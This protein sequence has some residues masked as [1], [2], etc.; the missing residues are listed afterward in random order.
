MPSRHGTTTE[1]GLLGV[2]GPE[3]LGRIAHQSKPFIRHFINAHLSAEPK[4]SPYRAD[5]PKR[6]VLPET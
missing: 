4:L 3:H 1:P 6:S 5:N 2:A